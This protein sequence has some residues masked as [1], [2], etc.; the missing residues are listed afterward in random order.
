MLGHATAQCKVTTLKDRRRPS[1]T[2]GALV[3]QH[4][5]TSLAPVYVS[6]VA[7]LARPLRLQLKQGDGLADLLSPVHMYF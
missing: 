2:A 7:K 3:L 1:V 5:H 4:S 6:N